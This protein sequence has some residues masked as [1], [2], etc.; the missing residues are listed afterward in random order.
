[1]DML[2]PMSASVPY[3][4][5]VGNHETDWPD[6]T[7]YYNGHDSGG[8][9]SKAAFKFI[10]QPAPATYEK[11]W[12]AYSV[13]LIHFIGL[14]SEQNFTK[15]SEQYLWFEEDLKKINRTETPWVI[16]GTHRAMYISSSWGPNNKNGKFTPSTDIANMNLMVAN[17]E[18]LLW[19]YKVNLG[20]YGHMHCVQRQAAILEQKVVQNAKMIKDDQGNDLAMHDDPQATVHYIIGT[21]GANLMTTI[22]P[23]TPVWNERNFF[24]WGYAIIEAVNSTKLTFRWVESSTNKVIDRMTITQR[25]PSHKNNTVFSCPGSQFTCGGYDPNAPKVSNEK[26][27]KLNDVNTLVI[28]GASLG[29]LFLLSFLFY[30][31]SDKISNF[32][33]NRNRTESEKRDST[34]EMGDTAGVSNPVLAEALKIEEDKK[35]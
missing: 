22:N 1:M 7:A 11:P 16:F 31:Y 2:S 25:D 15:N 17:L 34:V 4:T 24:R 6:T 9:C 14:S 29:G 12:W 28:V 30:Q 13:G 8:E 21:G 23:I 10:K 19:K 26:S 5:T 18:P 27:K 32:V 20:L 35:K 3:F 33:G